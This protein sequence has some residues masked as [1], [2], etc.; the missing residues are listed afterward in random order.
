MPHFLNTSEF[1]HKIQIFDFRSSVYTLIKT[2]SSLGTV[3]VI[4]NT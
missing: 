3:N 2:G 1:N 4:E